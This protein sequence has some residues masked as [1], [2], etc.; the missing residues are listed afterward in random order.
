M[1][2]KQRKIMK[3]YRIRPDLVAG[4]N[5]LSERLNCTKTNILEVAL[6]R[7]IQEMVLEENLKPLKS[8]AGCQSGPHL[9]H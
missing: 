6:E 5:D 7:Y 9:T 8:P 3:N 2:K 1:K 4:I